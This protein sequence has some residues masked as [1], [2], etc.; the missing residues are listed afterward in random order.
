V[1]PS[2]V[3]DVYEMTVARY[4]AV[5]QA[6]YTGAREVTA[7][8]AAIPSSATSLADEQTAP[9]CTYSDQ[10]SGR[11][12]MPL[13]CVSW[14]TAR[15]VCQFLGGDL[16]TEAEW[17]YVSAQ[18]GRAS[19]T[20]YSWGDA[21]PTC[22]Q[23]IFARGVDGITDAPDACSSLGF[24]PQAV[25]SSGDLSLGLNVA[26]LAGSA[27]E[28]MLDSAESLASRCWMSAPLEAASCQIPGTSQY[29]LRGAAWMTPFGS[30]ITLLATTRARGSSA[31]GSN[32]A[33]GFR[34]VRS[35][36]GS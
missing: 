12:T 22:S 23:A 8:D 27:T 3:V 7:N 16:P 1:V 26:D 30:P 17:E 31:H 33:L 25:G 6:G 35:G 19:K 2:F 29:S 9:Y 15:A 32:P 20:R 28:W 21:T 14:T 24:G 11:E 34:C 4:R 5:L 36:G 10:P 13:T 18:A